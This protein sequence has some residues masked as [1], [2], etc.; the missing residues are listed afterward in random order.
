[1]KILLAF[2]LISR[3]VGQLAANPV[4]PESNLLKW[5]LRFSAAPASSRR[6]LGVC[7]I[8]NLLVECRGR[9]NVVGW[10]QL[11]RCS[12]NP[13]REHEKRARRQINRRL[14]GAERLLV[15]L[16]HCPI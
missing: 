16:V 9:R 13:P 3:T 8:G 14:N 11:C 4:V 12:S 6:P 7:G 2:R 10:N 15:V 5:W 1:M